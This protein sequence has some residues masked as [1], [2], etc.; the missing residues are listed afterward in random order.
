MTRYDWKGAALICWPYVALGALIVAIL[1][2]ATA[3]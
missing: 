3:R 2:A 1:L